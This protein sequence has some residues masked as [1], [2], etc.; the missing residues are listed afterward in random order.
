MAINVCIAGATGWVGRSLVPAIC[1]E[2]D[3]NLV[4][5]VSRTHAG[6]KLSEVLTQT[7]P[8][9]TISGSVKEALRNNTDVLVDY[10]KPNV[11]KT[12]V[13]E[14]IQNKTHVVIG[15][16]GLTE[17]DFA[18]IHEQAIKYQVGV[19]AAGNFAITAVLLQRFAEIAA[20]YTSAWEIVDYASQKKVDAP[21]GTARELAFRL[22]QVKKPILYNSIEETQGSKES[23]GV[24][25]NGTQVHSLR[26]PGY[27]LSVEAI[28]GLADEKLIIRHEAGS[29]AEPYVKGTL[30]AIRQVSSFF[31]LKRGLDSIMQL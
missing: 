23:R 9:L 21:S 3:L 14:A 22:G 17:E 31:G 8:D 27:T 30:L 10:T 6:K 28:F 5:A 20:R 7:S 11:V 29:S 24:T 26:L 15:T 12:N 18:Q 19:L 13:L 16:S 25:L 1:A 2:K 4:G